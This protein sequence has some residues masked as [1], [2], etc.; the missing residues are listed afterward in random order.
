MMAEDFIFT[1]SH[2]MLHLPFFYKRF[3]KWHH[4]YNVSVGICAEYAHPFEFI[5]GNSL[6][7]ALPCMILG[8]KMHVFTYIV[9]ATYRVA[10]TVYGH[11]G[12][13]FDWVFSDLLPF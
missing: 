3:H 6:P 13:D 8:S 11:S 5:F 4:K 12:Y 1:L 2:R 9:W 10:N 7:F